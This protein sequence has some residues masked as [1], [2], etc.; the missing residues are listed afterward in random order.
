MRTTSWRLERVSLAAL[1]ALSLALPLGCGRNTAAPPGG[2]IA[3]RIVWTPITSTGTPG[4]DFPDWRGDSIAFQIEQGGIAAIATATDSGTGSAFFPSFA[5]TGDRTPRWIGPDL[6]IYS[7]DRLGTADL[8]YLNPMTG[9]TRRLTDFP[10]DEVTPAPRPGSPGLAYVE[11]TGPEG[12]RLV[13]LPDTA[14]T[15]IARYYLTPA[16][17]QATEPDWDPTGT[18]IC[19]TAPDAV[20]TPHIWRLSLTDTLAIQLTTGPSADRSPRWSPDGTSIVFVSERNGLSGIWT[21]SPAGEGAGLMVWAYDRRG[22]TIRHPTWSPGGLRWLLS[23]DRSG[24]R[25]L[26]LVSWVWI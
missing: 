16:S 15:P 23:S 14:A 25:A 21:V 19:F 9:A 7:S 13:L 5:P 1:A 8:W 17:L 24:Q 10:G 11:R 18:Q 12:G 22:A 3:G 4:P 20:G 6:L 26:W 2:G